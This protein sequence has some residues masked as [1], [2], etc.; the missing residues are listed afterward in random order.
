MV[1]KIMETKQWNNAPTF[2]QDIVQP[3]GQGNSLYVL[4]R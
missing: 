4:V 2:K 1:T 3:N